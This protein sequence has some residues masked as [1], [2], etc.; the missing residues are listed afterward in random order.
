ML[1]IG[2]IVCVFIMVF[3]GYILA[4]GNIMPIIHHAPL[5]L[6]TILGRWCRGVSDRQ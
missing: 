6:M 2:G 1:A 3:G 4:G 5:E